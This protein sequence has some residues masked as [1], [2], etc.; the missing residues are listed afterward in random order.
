MSGKKPKPR[1]APEQ[2][3]GDADKAMEFLGIAKTAAEKSP[4]VRIST[5]IEV[6]QLDRLRSWGLR[7]KPPILKDPALLRRAIE[8]VLGE[9]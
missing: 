4:L 1:F 3:A 8:S 2:L 5:Q 7:Q 6:S 9:Q